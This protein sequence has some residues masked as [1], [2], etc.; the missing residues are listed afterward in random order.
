MNWDASEELEHL[1]LAVELSGVDAPECVL[2]NEHDAVLRGMRLHYLD[3]GTSGR[4]PVLF[5]HGGGLTAHTWD[6]VCLAMRRAHHCLALDQRGHGDSEWSPEMD[7]GPEAHVR[8]IEGLVDR[9]G[10]ERFVLVGQ[11]MGALNGLVY[12]ARHSHR[13]RGLVVVDAGPEVRAE[14]AQRIA[15]FLGRTAEVDSVDAFVH[16][17]RA[18]NPLRDPRLLRHSVRRNLRALPDGRWMRK[19]DM[20][21]WRRTGVRQLM[22]RARECWQDVARITCPTLVVRGALSEVF[23]DEDAEKLARALPNGRWVRVA[24]AGHTIQGD[25]PR[26]LVE[27]MLAFFRDLGA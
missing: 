2:P 25:N 21:S 5:L 26:G 14:G 11:S 24:G 20:R 17:A 4:P 12:A 7:Y 13:L 1:R 18:F 19:H 23:L 15:D 6:V 22:A 16:S 27:A 3:W 10:L 8:D 9:L